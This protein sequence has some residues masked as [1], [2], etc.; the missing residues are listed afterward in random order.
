MTERRKLLINTWILEKE[1]KKM[2]TNKTVAEP[3]NTYS[4]ERYAM[5]LRK[6]RADVE[7]E[8]LGEGE[9]LA[10]H[11]AALEVLAAKHDIHPDQITVYQEI[12]SGE[13]I[14]D[15]PEMQRLLADVYMKKYKGVL[16]MEVERLARGNTKDQG[17][18]ADAFQYG[19][20]LIITPNKTYDPNNE[21]DEEY[22]EFGLFMSRR[23]YKTIRR[24]ML[25][26]KY[27]SVKEGNY[28]GTHRIFGYQIQRLNKK[29]R[30]LVI[31][32]EEAKIVQ[33]IF[34][35]YTE[36]QL[37][38]GE[39]ARRL[40]EMGIKP[41][42][43]N[44]W[45]VPTIRQI[46]KNEHY[47][48]KIRYFRNGIK[49]EFNP[50]TGKV[51]KKFAYTP[52]R[53]ELFPGKHKA[54]ISE[55]QFE[56]AQKIRTAKDFNPVK[57]DLTLKNHYAG[58]IKCCDCGK[59]MLYKH[60][61]DRIDPVLFH[62]LSHLC[63]KKKSK[64]VKVPSIDEAVIASLK[65]MIADFEIKIESNHDQSELIRHQEMIDLME[66]ELLKQE[67]KRK[68]LFDDYEDEVYTKE[69]F[70]ER[71][72]IYNQ[73]IEELKGKIKEAK[74]NL[75]ATVNYEETIHHIHEMI[76]C[77]NNPNLSAKSKNDFLKKFIDHITLETIDLGRRN[78]AMPVLEI[79]LKS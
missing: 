47:I 62:P 8:A 78:G 61:K 37:G 66:K 18:V 58:L 69:E 67:R 23:E 36:E 30:I 75:P 27:A 10:R 44:E 20:A 49:K 71:K 56:K 32:P 22:F 60:P 40:M 74:D 54:I 28:I 21:F 5:Y 17:E 41:L 6:S 29:E 9:T 77:L 13:S 68:K 11:R 16:V 63:E 46:I 15:R 25:A 38:F 48:G 73:S 70:V 65:E 1:V 57:K 14:Q 79:F 12:V 26:G 59:T 43:T 31:D 2:A 76:E 39:I 50:D 4:S 3:I 64:P 51:D 7:L 33:M 42:R 55:E 53:M 24:R 19:Q 34:D 45:G 72:Q 35:W 52:E